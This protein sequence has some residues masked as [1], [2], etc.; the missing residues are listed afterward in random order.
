M[1]SRRCESSTETRLRLKRSRHEAWPHQDLNSFILGSLLVRAASAGWSWDDELPRREAA[2]LLW[3]KS[4]HDT[5]KSQCLLY[6]PKSG[7]GSAYFGVFCSRRS[8]DASR[9]AFQPRCYGGVHTGAERRVHLGVTGF[10]AGCAFDF[11]KALDFV[12]RFCLIHSSAPSIT[13]D[14]NGDAGCQASCALLS[15]PD[16]PGLSKPA[17][18]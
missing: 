2:C 11:R 17:R 13:V 9:S 10:S 7:H 15:R 12:V 18:C 3:V 8:G 6:P 16:R 1:R 14:P 4:R 5:L